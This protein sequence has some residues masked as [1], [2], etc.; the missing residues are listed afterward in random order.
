M[1]TD[2]HTLNDFTLIAI[3]SHDN[4][5]AFIEASIEWY[6]VAISISTW[7]RQINPWQCQSKHPL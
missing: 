3:T 4:R 2:Q 1:D 6:L 5:Q 7:Y